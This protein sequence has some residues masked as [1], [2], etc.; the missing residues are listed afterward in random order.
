MFALA[1]QCRQPVFVQNFYARPF[2]FL[3]DSVPNVAR[4]ATRHSHSS[5]AITD[6]QRASIT[7]MA[8][9]GLMVKLAIFSVAKKITVYLVARVRASIHQRKSLSVRV[10][11]RIVAFISEMSCHHHPRLHVNATQTYG[12]PK[13]Y[14]RLLRWNKHL[15]SDAERRHKNQKI[16]QVTLYSRATSVFRPPVSRLCIPS[17]HSIFDT[18]FCAL[19]CVNLHS[20]CFAG[21]NLRASGGSSGN[22][23]AETPLPLLRPRLLPSL[24]HRLR[25]RHRHQSR[26][27]LH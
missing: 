6:T 2:E 23:I 21:R 24:Q 17:F 14:R 15:F 22:S 3:A 4:H 19:R 27:R 7:A 1:E 18:V 9:W 12:F 16:L 8:L 20:S 10:Q 11:V 5:R 26:L 13:I 25:R